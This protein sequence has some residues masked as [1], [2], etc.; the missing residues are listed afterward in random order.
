MCLG[1][2]GTHCMKACGV[3][4][5]V[6]VACLTRTMITGETV[7]TI[8]NMTIASACSRLAWVISKYIFSLEWKCITECNCKCMR[9]EAVT[10]VLMKCFS[11]LEMTPCILVYRYQ[12]FRGGFFILR[13][14]TPNNWFFLR[15]S[16]D[17]NYKLLLNVGTS[18]PIYTAS[19]SIT[20]KFSI[21]ICEI[22]LWWKD[23]CY[24]MWQKGRNKMK[25]DRSGLIIYLILF[26]YI[27]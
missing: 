25:H 18:I 8:T 14:G 1:A 6:C 16:K 21:R 13:Q 2:S 5:I 26:L 27:L 15:Y 7:S 12:G 23:V 9:F 17:G 4:W 10:A 20:L 11:F 24:V 22:Y 3:T 19:F